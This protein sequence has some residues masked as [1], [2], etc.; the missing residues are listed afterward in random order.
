MSKFIAIGENIHCTRIFKVGGANVKEVAPGKHAITYKDGE[1]T[2]ALVVPEKF[3]KSADWQ[4]EKIKHCAVAIWQGVYGDKDSG[5]HYITCKAQEQEKA[6]AS[7]LDINVDEFSTDVDERVKLMKWTVNIAQKAV[8]I[9][10]SI[11]SS[12]EAIL[13][14]GLEAADKSRGKPMVNSVSLERVKAIEVAARHKAVVIA[15]AAGEKGLPASTD[16]KLSNLAGLMKML[17]ASGF[18]DDSIY[19]DPLV[20]P[21]STDGNNGKAFLEAVAS[22]RKTYGPAIHI[23][24]GFSNVSFGMPARKLINQ[25]FSYLAVENGADGGI[26]DPV[27]INEKILQA[28]DPNSESFK[29]AKAL[30]LGE[31]EYGMEFIS[32]SRDGRI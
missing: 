13:N 2:C 27:Q 21:I 15:S 5:A 10:V 19:I 4:A 25:V 18:A 1:K 23:S 20:F 7:F 32:A 30:L 17:K 22:I 12:N 28:L 8:K 6:G 3:V 14:A 24:G 29:L 31:D 16:E 11:D 26:V 9:P